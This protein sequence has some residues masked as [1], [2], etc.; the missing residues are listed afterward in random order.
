MKGTVLAIAI[1]LFSHP[2]QRSVTE[3]SERRSVNDKNHGFEAVS[4]KSSLSCIQDT[5]AILRK[6]S[7]TSNVLTSMEI[8]VIGLLTWPQMSQSEAHSCPSL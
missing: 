8:N 2:P 7:F 3:R 6:S 4:F 1:A 5:S